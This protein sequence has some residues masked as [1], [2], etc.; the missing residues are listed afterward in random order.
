MALITKNG[1]LKLKKMQQDLL[2]EERQAIEDVA[3]ARSY[4]DF[5][6]NAELEVANARLERAKQKMGEVEALLADAELFNVGLIDRSRVNFG[7]EVHV[8]DE[9]VGKKFC[10]RIVDETEA[11]IKE[12]KIS[13]KSPLAKAL[14]GKMVG[15]DCEF[16]AP[17]GD[18]AL[19]IEQISYAWL[20]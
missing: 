10:Y 12:N 13:V 17:S 7:A 20:D 9:S 3:V 19:L 15:D 2:V 18:R 14:L 1:L 4:G 8:S 16:S 5:S 11:D 6:E